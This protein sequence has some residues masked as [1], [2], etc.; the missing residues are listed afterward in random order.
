M[1]KKNDL[2]DKY[3]QDMEVSKKD[4]A[5]TIEKVIDIIKTGI[6]EDDGVDTQDRVFIND[7][8]IERSNYIY[9]T[10]EPNKLTSVYARIS[11]TCTSSDYG[12][13]YKD[14]KPFLV[15]VGGAK[16]YVHDYGYIIFCSD[17]KIEELRDDYF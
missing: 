7:R 9:E 6:I 5:T 17:L 13:F 15:E 11:T 14:G 2:I 12:I 10:R 8:I 3:A 4:A 16:A 1:L